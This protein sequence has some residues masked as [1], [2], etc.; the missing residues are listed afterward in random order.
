[1]DKKLCDLPSLT[2]APIQVIAFLAETLCH[3]PTT[4]DESVWVGAIAHMI[5]NNMSFY[6]TIDL[7]PEKIPREFAKEITVWL[8][9]SLIAGSLFYHPL[10]I[11]GGCQY[12]EDLAEAVAADPDAVVNVLKL[13]Y[14][15]DWDITN[16]VCDGVIRQFKAWYKNKDV[17][18][19]PSR[20]AITS[21]IK[22]VRM[23]CKLAAEMRDRG[24]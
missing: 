23:A 17:L 9:G 3:V 22:N 5:K 2:L 7:P 6:S 1:M 8:T 21:V 12:G 13:V 24:D 11:N 14:A 16:S 18:A 10:G 19:I 20:A 15:E 4:R